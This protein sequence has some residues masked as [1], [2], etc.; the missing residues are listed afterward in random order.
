MAEGRD[1]ADWD[2]HSVLVARMTNLW[3]KARTTPQKENP[4]RQDEKDEDHTL[5]MKDFRDKVKARQ[6][7]MREHGR[8]C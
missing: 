2:M 4:Y 8:K 7:A 3:S 6:K 5:S 1:K